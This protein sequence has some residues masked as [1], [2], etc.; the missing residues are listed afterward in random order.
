MVTMLLNSVWVGLLTAQKPI[1]RPGWWKGEFALFQMSTTVCGVGWQTCVQRSTP[2]P[3][4]AGGESFYRQSWGGEVTCR[5]STVIF[6]LVISNLT[7][8]ILVILGTVNLQFQG[9]HFFPFLCRHF[10]ELWQLMS[11]VWSG[12]RVDNFFTWCFGIYTTAHR[13]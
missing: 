1:H 10:S 12:H 7:G 3:R 6:K 11:W 8:I 5:K 13:I 4:E 9:I 2:T